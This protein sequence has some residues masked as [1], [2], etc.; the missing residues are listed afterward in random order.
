MYDIII[1]GS[2]PAG[3]TA[4][5]Y[6]KRSNK[7]TLVFESAN[8]GGKIV[9]ATLIENYP[10]LP[11]ISGFDYAN[12]IYN[13]AKEMGV[14]FKFERVNEIKDYTDH[15]EVITSKG[16]YDCKSIILATGNENRY[17]GLSGE[18]ELIGKGISYCATC[19][20]SFYKGKDVC[21][22][23]G[24]NIAVGDA[25]YL[26]D[27][28]SKVYLVYRKSELSAEGILVD[29]LKE[30]KNVEVIL[31]SS[32][33][34][35]NGK[36]KLESVT[37]KNNEDEYDLKVSGLFVAVGRNPQNENFKNLIKTDEKGFIIAGEDT[38][39]NIPGIF[40]AGDN[41]V[42]ALR[43]LVTACSDGANAAMEA[44]KYVNNKK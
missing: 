7:K 5:I 15:K 1:V 34:K 12:N 23:G 14:E 4:S 36:E 43:Q 39:T 27:I 35:L 9:D 3:I 33:I 18:K 8:P 25:I 40:A 38:H 32:V 13:Q 10:A 17:L 11:H 2:G 16:S 19:D 21:V 20:G 42:K 22:V 30:A 29:K 44:I 41:R 24:G 37:V 26:N 6:A 28:A 31:N